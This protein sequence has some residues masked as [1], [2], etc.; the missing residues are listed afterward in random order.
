MPSSRPIGAVCAEEAAILS[1]A[2]GYN[3]VGEKVFVEIA[4]K[5]GNKVYSPYS[6]GVAFSM[7]MSGARGETQAEI[8]KAMELKLTPAAVEETNAKLAGNFAEQTKH[9]GATPAEQCAASADKDCLKKAARPYV[10][11]ALANALMI[12]QTGTRIVQDY[13]EIV[14]SK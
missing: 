10:D 1:L 9:L 2:Y 5:P 8:L 4:R 3:A 11:L 12:P 7:A 14:T 13:R 6:A